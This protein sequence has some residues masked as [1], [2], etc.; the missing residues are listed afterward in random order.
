MASPKQSRDT[1]VRRRI[2]LAGVRLHYR[3]AG[4]GRRG[5]PIVV[6][7]GDHLSSARVMSLTNHLGRE[8]LTFALDFPG[9]GRSGNASRGRTDD[10]G[11]L[12]FWL[13]RLGFERA[14][15]VAIGCAAD[16]A[17]VATRRAPS[18]F[19]SLTLVSPPNDLDASRTHRAVRRLRRVR[20]GRKP[21]TA[22]GSELLELAAGVA[23]PLM[24]V[25][26]ENEPSSGRVV[27]ADLARSA[28]GVLIDLPEGGS[29]CY[30]T[31]ARSIASTLLRYWSS[32]EQ[33]DTAT[34]PS[35]KNGPFSE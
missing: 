5:A 25:R 15:L 4:R 18:R 23:V 33:A 22:Q 2:H 34:S 17:L 16:A 11:W 10:A 32:I 28:H 9:Q 13:S 24:V 27:A 21:A 26:G 30:R 20:S 3:V 12:I 14:H 31:H 7:T 1:P 29:D 19:A 35:Q 8:R 6:I